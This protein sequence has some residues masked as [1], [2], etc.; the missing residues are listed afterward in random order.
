MHTSQRLSLDI[1]PF[2]LTGVLHPTN[3]IIVLFSSARNDD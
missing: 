1:G 3:Q 2:Q